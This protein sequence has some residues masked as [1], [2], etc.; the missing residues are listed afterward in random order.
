MH[1]IFECCSITYC[2]VTEEDDQFVST[3]PQIQ[4]EPDIQEQPRNKPE[5]DQQEQPQNPHKEAQIEGMQ[6]FY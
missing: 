3:E 2:C 5:S 1:K 4:H 6:T